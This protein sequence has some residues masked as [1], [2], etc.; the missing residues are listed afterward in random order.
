MTIAWGIGRPV[1]AAS[2]RPSM[3]VEGW[4]T[5]VSSFGPSSPPV[6][7]AMPCT[8]NRGSRTASETVMSRPMPA[9]VKRP[10]SSVVTG[11]GQLS[12]SA[13]GK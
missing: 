3:I 8:A 11:R 5:I 10:D 4:R 7:T 2:A 6:R 13:G 1:S 12:T 9:S